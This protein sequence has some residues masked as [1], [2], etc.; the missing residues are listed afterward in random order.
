MHGGKHHGPSVMTHFLPGL[1]SGFVIGGI[2]GSIIIAHTASTSLH[3]YWEAMRQEKITNEVSCADISGV[4]IH[5]EI[6]STGSA[7]TAIQVG[8]GEETL[9]T[10]PKN[11][12]RY[13][14][15]TAGTEAY[16][17][18]VASPDQVEAFP[19]TSL[20]RVD[21]C[22]KTGEV[23]LG[24]SEEANVILGMSEKGTWAVYRGASGL[25]V[26]NTDEYRALSV[27][28][29]EEVSELQFSPS[30]NFISA[31]FASGTREIWDVTSGLQKESAP[32][33]AT[34]PAWGVDTKEKYRESLR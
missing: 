3:Y 24:D 1:L 25:M 6:S 12:L 31:R 14:P 11:R 15:S 17:T 16:F 28:T 10:I 18:A 30:E 22:K 32:S 4:R 27:E 29:S 8:D 2:V 9:L 19:A 21:F 26:M 23:L 13:V 34:L 5:E 20:Y 7:L 33:G